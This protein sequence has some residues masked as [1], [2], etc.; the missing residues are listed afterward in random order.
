MIV[1]SSQHLLRLPLD[2]DRFK[3]ND[4]VLE[5]VTMLFLHVFPF[6]RVICNA[7]GDH[8]FSTWEATT[9]LLHA[10]NRDS[11]SSCNNDDYFNYYSTGWLFESFASNTT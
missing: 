5:G 6:L 9:F 7:E 10:C 1:F 4:L 3:G 11:N 2:T 8:L